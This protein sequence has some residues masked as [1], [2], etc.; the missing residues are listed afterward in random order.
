MAIWEYDVESDLFTF[1]DGFYSIFHTSTLEIGGNMMLLASYVK[2]FVFPEDAKVVREE[3]DKAIEAADGD[4][5][6]QFTHRIVYAD[7]GIGNINVWISAIKDDNGKANKIFGLVQEIG[8]NDNKD[9]KEELQVR[10][11]EVEKYYKMV[12]DREL[13][14]VEYKNRIKLLEQKLNFQR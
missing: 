11:D 7:G 4:Y 14:I 10:S 13:L 5:N 8:E 6:Q 9:Y 12:I 3:I 2:R 1:N